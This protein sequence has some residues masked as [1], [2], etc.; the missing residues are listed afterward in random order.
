MSTMKILSGENGTFLKKSE[1]FLL[2]LR[3]WLYYLQHSWIEWKKKCFQGLFGVPLGKT[4]MDYAPVSWSKDA[5]FRGI[6]GFTFGA[7][8]SFVLFLFFTL[9]LC[10]LYMNFRK[11]GL[12][13]LGQKWR[14]IPEIHDLKSGYFPWLCLGFFF[15]SFVPMDLAQNVLDL[16]EKWPASSPPEKLPYKSW[17][18]LSYFCREGA[19]V[20]RV[21]GPMEE[22]TKDVL[23]SKNAVLKWRASAKKIGHNGRF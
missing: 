11:N 1:L 17:I 21:E 16:P 6:R 19:A 9:W 20:S 10:L 8:F 22:G 7:G 13:L 15:K 5:L 4:G 23:F 12:D 14:N 2:F 18:C 3:T